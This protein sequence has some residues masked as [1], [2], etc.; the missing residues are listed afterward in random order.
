MIKKQRD[1]LYRL[2]TLCCSGFDTI[3]IAPDIFK[4]VHTILPNEACALFL[5]HPN[6][7]PYMFFH[8][9][10]NESA[11]A[12]FQNEPQLFVGDSEYNV[13]KIANA[14]VK[15]GYF[16][17]PDKEYFYSNTYQQLV[18]ASGHHYALEVRLEVTN[19]NAGALILFREPSSKS[20]Q[21]ADLPTINQ[22]SRYIEYS[23]NSDTIDDHSSENI[24]IDTALIVIAPKTLEIQFCTSQVQIILQ[25]IPL[26]HNF[27]QKSK[28]LPNVCIQLVQQL[29]YGSHLPETK[30]KIPSGHLYL[31]A[32]W[33]NAQNHRDHLVA[34]HIKKIIPK[35]L[36]LWQS[37]QKTDLN[38]QQ[39]SVAFLL[40]TGVSK[41]MIQA[42]LIISE[43]VMK[44]CIK[45]IYQYFTV[46]S[47]D[48]L[49][50]L[51]SREDLVS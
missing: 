9:A 4:Y 48:E 38:A 25:E 21:C 20:F 24:E 43:A 10:T 8:E 51:L 3:S 36:K 13:F 32:E 17:N 12:L 1:A 37:L 33:L 44:D 16:L 11:R 5:T 15:S 29:Y 49:V 2:R 42:Q 19:K 28:P 27:W 22:I 18:R 26:V 14:S 30:L 35:S 40:V 6:G 47:L 50:K 45:L 34:L 7:M 39:A 41:K 46:H 31:R 23:L